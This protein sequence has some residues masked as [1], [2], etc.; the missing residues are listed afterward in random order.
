MAGDRGL[1]TVSLGHWLRACQ[2]ILMALH[3]K[4]GGI[5]FAGTSAA[6]R[7]LGLRTL[8]GESNPIVKRAGW[9]GR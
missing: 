3:Q 9:A 7:P 1:L 4:F 6:L 8:I 2:I 5:I